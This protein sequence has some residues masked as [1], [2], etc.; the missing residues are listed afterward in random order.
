MNPKLLKNIFIVTLFIGLQN[1]FAQN[2]REFIVDNA[3]VANIDSI[4][5]EV[6]GDDSCA[7]QEV[8]LVLD[9]SENDVIVTEKEISTCGKESI[10]YTLKY[11]W[12]IEDNE[13]IT[14]SS[15]F[16]ET[17][18]NFIKDLSLKIENKKLVG[19]TKDTEVFNFKLIK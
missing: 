8:Y 11:K 12:K 6:V 1:V 4:C 14:L 2:S 16:K 15:N 10:S 9:F 7:G 18:P 5:E 13:T 3:F 17:G 19:Y